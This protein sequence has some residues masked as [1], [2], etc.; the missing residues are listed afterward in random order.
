[1][2]VCM[3]VS[4]IFPKIKIINTLIHIYIHT[5]I[6]TFS[7]Q[8]VDNAFTRRLLLGG[9]REKIRRVDAVPVL[10]LCVCVCVFVCECN[11]ERG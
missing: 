5:H 3:S 8:M 4:I 10:V 11:E 1:M 2:Y 6:H 9:C 7:R